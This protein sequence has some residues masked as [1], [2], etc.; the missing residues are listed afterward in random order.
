MAAVIWAEPLSILNRISTRRVS[1]N[2]L[3]HRWMQVLRDLKELLPP[4]VLWLPSHPLAGSNDWQEKLSEL[5][6]ARRSGLRTPETI[7][8]NDPAVA[9][10]FLERHRGKVL[11][12]D[13]SK[14]EIRFFTMFAT[15]GAR[16]RRRLEHS[17]CGFQ[18][19]VDKEFDVRAVAIGRRI[20]ACRIDSQASPSARMDWRVYDNAR[21]KWE[22]M[23]LPPAVEA[24][25]LRMM[26]ALGI[27][28]GSFDL[29]RGR[30]GFYYFLEVNRPGACY[31][32]L[33]FVGLDVPAELAR[34]LAQTL[35]RRGR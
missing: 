13:L 2:L 4:D 23:R 30:D 16:Q 11:F 14:T 3:L 24:A 10:R 12:R 29:V 17:P 1:R 8:T 6:I 18:R 27:T 32:L 20:F 34:H 33:P 9:G 35:R 22:R 21:V 15:L 19:Y 5:A 26:K 25:I 31:W 7:L 28:W